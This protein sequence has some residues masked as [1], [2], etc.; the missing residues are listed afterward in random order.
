M[1]K[2]ERRP[3]ENK[4]LGLILCAEKNE[5]HI[6]LLELDKSGIHVAQY[7][8]ALPAREA[9]EERFRQAVVR[10]KEKYTHR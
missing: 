6:E 4:S 3:G 1:D 10:A 5:E 7:L 2:Y 9:L 8:T